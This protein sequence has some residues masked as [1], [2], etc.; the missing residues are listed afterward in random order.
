MSVPIETSVAERADLQPASTVVKSRLRMAIDL[1][2]PRERKNAIFVLAIFLVASVTLALSVASVYPFLLVLTQQNAIETSEKMSW[3][4][5][6]LGS[7]S[8]LSF[9]FL[10]GM[11]T[12]ALL[13]TNAILQVLRIYIVERFTQMQ[14]HSI[15]VRLLDI[16]MSQ[17]MIF[18]L[19]RNTGDMAKG[20]L[21]ET[22]EVVGQ[23]YRPAANLVAGVLGAL[24][25]IVVLVLLAPFVTMVA[26]A[27]I[28]GSYAVVYLLTR[29][30]LGRM[31]L[32]R[33]LSN[34]ERHR[35]SREALSGIKDIKIA[36]TERYF[37]DNYSRYSVRVARN[38]SK[39]NFINL[40]PRFM[41]EGIVFTSLVAF[42]LIF[43]S[44]EMLAGGGL[45]SGILPELG[46]MALGAQRLLPEIQ[47]I[48]QSISTIRFGAASL[49]SVHADMSMPVESELGDSLPKRDIRL[50]AELELRNVS[51]AYPTSDS[52]ALSEINL[53]IRK[54]QRIGIV[55][56]T[57]AGKS[58]LAD[59]ILGLLRPKEGDLVVDGIPLADMDIRIWQK[60][61]GYVPQHIF[62]SDATVAE[63]IA[64]GAKAGHA[65]QARIEKAARIAQLH[66]FIK[67]TLPQGYDTSI[68]ENGVRLSG[69]QRQR[70]GIAR[71]LY[72]DADLIVFDE[73][74]SAL[75]SVTESELVAAIDALPG[76]KTLLIIAHRLTTV[77]SC[78][79][80]IVMN[81]GRIIASGNWEE[82]MKNSPDFRQL[83]AQKSD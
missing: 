3:L 49:A 70:I 28:V 68:G 21:D 33:V 56:T 4:H 73:A 75:D 9:I 18:F 26:L 30:M 50:N 8:H 12:I 19:G 23:F 71:A 79:Q 81:K 39:A 14:I 17:P 43:L 6:L 41:L 35:I 20:I 13:L 74:T 37:L 63:N 44:E 83:V 55:G 2:T 42:P 38:Q 11:A 57:G 52:L 64:L 54:G 66:R 60:A 82:N 58:T 53:R 61:I 46:M 40:A 51:F 36:G 32:S 80:I 72:R 5:G 76:E 34:S 47:K 78:D 22:R 27:V 15:S 24:S 48:Y 62:L 10:L 29:G 1:L 25:V 59:L 77:R 45:L 16:F 69:G 67:D 65:D 31:G 7:P